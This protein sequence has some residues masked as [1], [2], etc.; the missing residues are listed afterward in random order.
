MPGKELQNG[1][2]GHLPGVITPHR[3]MR[4]WPL[5]PGYH[6]DPVLAE[7]C[8]SFFG[9][10]LHFTRG[11]AKGHQFYLAEWI[12]PYFRRFFGTVDGRGARQYREMFIGV[13]KK[14]GKSEIGG[15]L[16]LYMLCA[17]REPSPECYSLAMDKEQASICFNVASS[18]I[19]Q[20]RRLAGKTKVLGPQ[21]YIR[22]KTNDGV[23]R[24]LSSEAVGK[25][26]YSPSCVIFDEIHE[27]R[28]RDLWNVMAA[29]SASQ[30]RKSPLVASLTTAGEDTS[31]AGHELYQRALRIQEGKVEDPRMLVCI[32]GCTDEADWKDR[33]VWQAV[34]PGWDITFEAERVAEPLQLVVDH[35]N[36]E[37]VAYAKRM[38]LNMWVDKIHKDQWVP[39]S[40]WDECAGGT[41]A[42]QRALS[43]AGSI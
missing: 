2:N 4:N 25:Q 19:R 6:Y 31:G 10:Y 36:A 33:Q 18:M 3:F 17:D 35:G 12:A 29:P 30:A 21:K 27:Q 43:Q 34:N 5:L 14:N 15:A 16:A 40:A 39:M 28:H 8:I 38:N 22:H 32:Y 26:G 20:D 23:Y 37:E 9:E 1:Q 7:N 24:V 42:S 11:E 13:P 41:L